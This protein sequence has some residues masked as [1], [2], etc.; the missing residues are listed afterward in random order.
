MYRVVHFQAAEEAKAIQ[1][2]IVWKRYGCSFKED[3]S[4]LKHTGGRKG[5]V[6]F[7]NNTPVAVGFFAAVEYFR[8]KLKIPEDGL[9]TC[10]WPS[11]QEPP[12]PQPKQ[13]VCKKRSKPKPKQPETKKQAPL[14]FGD[15]AVP[16]DLFNF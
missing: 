4:V 5:V 8:Q 2:F 3:R 6:L 16:D 15:I 1:R 14:D 11:R 9:L 7:N 12:K 10:T 13:V